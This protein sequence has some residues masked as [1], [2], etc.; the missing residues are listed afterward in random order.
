MASR[1]VYE[2]ISKA[3]D[4]YWRLCV[5][6]AYSEC[7]R[8]SVAQ[9]R[10]TQFMHKI[11]SKVSTE[12]VF[13][14]A[15]LAMLI[16]L[17]DPLDVDDFYIAM[18]PEVENEESSW[19]N[20][21]HL[22]QRKARW[23]LNQACNAL[24]LISPW[25]DVFCTNTAF[26][27]NDVVIV[28][29]LPQGWCDA[30]HSRDSNTVPVS[31]WPTE[32]VLESLLRQALCRSSSSLPSGAVISCCPYIV[33]SSVSGVICAVSPVP[34]RSSE[35]VGSVK[36]T[37]RDILDAL[38]HILAGAGSEQMAAA[39]NTCVGAP[40]IP[41][42]VNQACKDLNTQMVQF[43]VEIPAVVKE[44]PYETYYLTLKEIK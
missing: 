1:N 43:Q 41:H 37:R 6:S 8:I 16:T 36:L 23:A 28:L 21:L 5:Q 18:P 9:N 40:S 33:D 24:W 20:R 3:P 15:Y 11:D 27:F 39:G 25:E 13:Y 22:A 42:R 19:K 14:R 10:N 35:D 30:C 34:A 2:V 44:M 17:R 4:D 26:A 12:I 38:I 32:T 7:G 31:M 29:S